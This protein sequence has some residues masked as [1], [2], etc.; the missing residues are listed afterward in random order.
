MK[1]SHDKS[2]DFLETLLKNDTSTDDSW[3]KII[4]FHKAFKQKEFWENLSNIEIEKEQ[5]EL[6]EWIEDLQ[7][8]SPIPDDIISFWIGIIKL[9]DEE[10][11]KEVCGIYLVGAKNY[12]KEDIEWAVDYT[13]EPENKYFAS[14]VLSSINENIE[15]DDDFSFLDWILPLSYC[16]LTFQEIFKNRKLNNSCYVSVGFDGGDFLNLQLNSI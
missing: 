7:I 8:E 9:W 14:D 1:F 16:C 11:E 4:D 15:D 5:K 13:Y 6:V 12:N 3:R 2:W 10:N